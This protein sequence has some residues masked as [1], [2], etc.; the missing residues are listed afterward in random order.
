M[1]VSNTWLSAV[2][3][4]GRPTRSMN[5]AARTGGVFGSKVPPSPPPPS[6][7]P[8]ELP[9][10]DEELPLDEDELPLELEPLP[11]LD[12]LLLEAASVPPS[13]LVEELLLEQATRAA[14]ETAA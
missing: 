1:F 5:I 13:P 3:T 6:P 7:P 14:T 10:L 9:E 4:A 2:L 11:E 8:E 12:E